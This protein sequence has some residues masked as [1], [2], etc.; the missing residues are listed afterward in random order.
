MSVE[1]DPLGLV[2]L[3]AEVDERPAGNSPV[4][5]WAPTIYRLAY[6]DLGILRII[7]AET[8]TSGKSRH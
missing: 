3:F 1:R 6:S 8:D 5:A 4:V 7:G 2:S